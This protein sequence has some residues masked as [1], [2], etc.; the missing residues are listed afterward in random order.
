[1]SVRPW[2][3]WTPVSIVVFGGNS[4]SVKTQSL[5]SAYIEASTASTASTGWKIAAT[6]GVLRDGGYCVSGTL[7]PRVYA[8]LPLHLNGQPQR[9]E[10][11][12]RRSPLFSGLLPCKAERA[13]DQA[14]CAVTSCNCS[15]SQK[16]SGL[17]ASRVCRT[18]CIGNSPPLIGSGR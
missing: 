15:T 16:C 1:M 11:G 5:K 4:G 17:L 12:D 6:P 9:A 10:L 7:S 3:R 18:A 2:T 14:N 8:E 13:Y